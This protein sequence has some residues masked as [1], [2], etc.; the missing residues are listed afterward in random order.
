MAYVRMSIA[1]PNAGKSLEAVQ[2][3]HELN[4][5]IAATNECVNTFVIKPQDEDGEVIRV[6]VFRDF[7]S[8]ENERYVESIDLFS[9]EMNRCFVKNREEKAFSS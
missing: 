8:Y 1:V 2:L 7:D 9:N 5:Q 3:M 4:K 6:A